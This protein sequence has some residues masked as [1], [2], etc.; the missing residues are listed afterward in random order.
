MVW[1]I[2]GTMR[3]LGMNLPKSPERLA[4]PHAM[5]PKQ[6]TFLSKSLTVLQQ[7][8]LGG[9]EGNVSGS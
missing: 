3:E 8:N 2:I 5:E 6:P 4:E 7:L 9:S 1:N